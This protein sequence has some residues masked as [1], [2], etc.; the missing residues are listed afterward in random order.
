[1]QT[2]T[3][4]HLLIPINEEVYKFSFVYVFFEHRPYDQTT[5]MRMYK[6]IRKLHTKL[7][8]KK[9]TSKIC[10]KS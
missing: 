2:F 3:D 5:L 8:I 4:R 9:I 10:A 6:Q 7:H 1:M